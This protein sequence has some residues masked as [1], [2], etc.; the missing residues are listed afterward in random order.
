MY[1][2]IKKFI[3]EENKPLGISFVGETL[4][5]EKYMIER[6]FSSLASLEYIV[7]G[8]GTLEINGQILHPQ[9]GDIFLLTKGSRHKYYPKKENP[10]HKYF[11]SFYGPVSDMLIENYIDKDTYLFKNTMC[12]KSFTHIFDIAF[13]S[14]EPSKIQSLLSVEIFKLFNYIFDSTIIENE[15]FA[16]K[17]KRYIENHITDE[18][19][20]E[21][22]CED[23]NYSKNHIINIFSQKYNVTP[24]QYYKK[25]KIDLA[26][27]YLVNT[28]MNVGEISNALS[29]TDQQ[30][31]SYSFKKETGYSP[32]QYRELMKV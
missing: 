1:E 10:W 29:F 7:D 20:L 13:S 11:I 30:Y 24:Y 3:Y 17:V 6:D 31:F 15:D 18:F 26:K 28:K 19:S 9:K 4:C 16:D 27:E 23:M 14:S 5:D 32:K 8:E 2:N 22:L 12:E 25:C 21:G